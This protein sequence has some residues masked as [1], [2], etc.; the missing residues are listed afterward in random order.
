[1]LQVNKT[2]LF[3]SILVFV[4]TILS[5]LWEPIYVFMISM[6]RY[7]ARNSSMQCIEHVVF[8]HINTK[9]SL[10]SCQ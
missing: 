10:Y 6:M 2:E 7:C 4:V 3:C 9:E 5:L 1:M 8:F